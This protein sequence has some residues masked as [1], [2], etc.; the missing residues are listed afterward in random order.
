[1]KLTTFVTG[2]FKWNLANTHYNCW[3]ISIRIVYFYLKYTNIYNCQPYLCVSVTGSKV[4]MSQMANND[5]D[6]QMCK[7]YHILH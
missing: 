5:T 3:K 2:L 1:M 7:C 6:F 4:K